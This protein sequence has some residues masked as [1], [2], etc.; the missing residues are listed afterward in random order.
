MKNRL[1]LPAIALLTTVACDMLP[2]G[3]DLA[4]DSADT[5][6]R[7]RRTDSAAAAPVV[8]AAAAHDTV[9]STAYTGGALP[10]DLFETSGIAVGSDGR[11]WTHNDGAEG[12]LYAL[13]AAGRITQRVRLDGV[14]VNDW[15]DIEAA[16]C[17]GGVCLYVADTGDNGGIRRSI[18]VHV[19]REPARGASAAPVVASLHARYPD[20]PQDAEALF[21]LPG[22][23]IYLVTK[24][25][26][27][28]IRLYRFPREARAQH[29]VTLEFIRELAPRPRD[30]RNRVTAAT[31]TADGSRVLIRTYRELL[32]FSAQ[33][34]VTNRPVATV[35][36]DLEHLRHVQGEAVAVDGDGNVWV[37]TEA[38]RIGL[39]RWARF[40]CR[41]DS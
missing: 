5:R 41:F 27:R 13:D 37:T 23:D 19:V 2:H 14:R 16:P 4:D 21:L 31:A 29:V 8:R 9:C 12:L 28:G 17:D 36:V 7:P 15:E 20:G 38:G 32:I 6:A 34:F 22:G 33:A 24:G 3:R 30:D 1:A 25:R 18:A 40:H 35:R 11:L 39:P 26:Q 10:R